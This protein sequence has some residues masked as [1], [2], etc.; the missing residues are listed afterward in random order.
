LTI[1]N[2]QSVVAG[3]HSILAFVI[4]NEPMHEYA[5][6]L[7]DLSNGVLTTVAPSASAWAQSADAKSLV[8]LDPTGTLFATPTP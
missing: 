8:Y 1:G 2:P 6:T 3:A 4:V 7:I 5:P